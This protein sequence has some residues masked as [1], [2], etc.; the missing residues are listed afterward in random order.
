MLTA[1]EKIVVA[2]LENGSQLDVEA[3]SK[4]TTDLVNS[5]C[6]KA[7]RHK[8]DKRILPLDTVIYLIAQIDRSDMSNAVVLGT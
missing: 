7:L 8:Y 3:S 1:Q 4:E 6:E 5:D 2:H